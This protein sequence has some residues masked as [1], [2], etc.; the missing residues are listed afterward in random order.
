MHFH[1]ETFLTSDV[2]TFSAE[3]ATLQSRQTDELY[4]TELY[5]CVYS[6]TNSCSDACHRSSSSLA[7]LW[8]LSSFPQRN[9]LISEDLFELV[10]I[11]K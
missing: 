3:M 9:S 10:A 6:L 4:A 8:Q 5:N 11:W 1:E 2:T 7:T